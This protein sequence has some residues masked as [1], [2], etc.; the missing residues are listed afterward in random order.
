MNRERRIRLPNVVKSANTTF[1]CK[2]RG[3]FVDIEPLADLSA[4]ADCASQLLVDHF[5]VTFS[6]VN[7][8]FNGA[9]Y[10][11]YNEVIIKVPVVVAA[12]PFIF[13]PRT[14]VDNELSLVR[15]YQLGF[16]KYMTA[17][18]G[19]VGGRAAFE[20]VG[21]H[22]EGEIQ[23]AEPREQTPALAAAA[24]GFVLSDGGAAMELVVSDHAQ[25]ADSGWLGAGGGGSIAGRAFDVNAARYTADRFVLHYATAL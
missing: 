16:N 12:R 19:A 22:I 10:V 23:P 20:W 13:P 24:G 8:N 18:E 5:F 4:P 7:S 25:S 6:T 11:A 1:S 9:D 17:V 3:G 15:G 21:L 2:V 14:Y